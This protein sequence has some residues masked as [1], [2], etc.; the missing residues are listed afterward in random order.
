MK[1][2]GS[3]YSHA[4]IAFNP[5]LDPLYSFGPNDP[6]HKNKAGFIQT[7]PDSNL[8]VIG[9]KKHYEIPYAVYVTFVTDD[10]LA[11]MK[12]R[13]EDFASKPALYKYNF[14]GLVRIYLG[15]PSKHAEK[16]FCSAF[17]AEILN[18]GRKLSKDSTLFKPDELTDIKN[19]EYVTHGYDIALYDADEVRWLTKEIRKI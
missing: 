15:R 1:A 18:S 16:W 6:L 2:T 19:V 12:S 9:T 8:W 5:E 11:R 3:R 14:E 7:N 13:V 17:V 10:E 4:S